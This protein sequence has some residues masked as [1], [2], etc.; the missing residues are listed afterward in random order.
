MFEKSRPGSIPWVYMFS[1][2]VMRSTFAGSL[3]V[4][5]QGSLDALGAGQNG[6]LGCRDTCAPVVVGMNADDCAVPGR[7]ITDEILD[8]IGKVVGHAALNR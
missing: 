8:L 1:A 4:S 2:S 7:Q 3:T 6:K 5:E